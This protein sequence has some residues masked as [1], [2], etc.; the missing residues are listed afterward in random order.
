ME[1]CSCSNAE[2]ME[3]PRVLSRHAEANKILVAMSSDW[4]P[5]NGAERYISAAC[6][7][8]T[9]VMREVSQTWCSELD[10]LIVWSD[11]LSMCMSVVSAASIFCSTSLPA[12]P[13]SVAPPPS[14][15]CP[16]QKAHMA[17]IMAVDA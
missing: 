9:R 6:A 10:H 3:A 17:I 15:P 7:A 16:R 11:P 14:P 12:T 5:P 2:A 8:R 1:A 4:G 13:A